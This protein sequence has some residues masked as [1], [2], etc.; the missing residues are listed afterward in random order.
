MQKQ[1]GKIFS[2]IHRAK[3]LMPFNMIFIF[4]I[5]FCNVVNQFLYLT[6]LIL[7]YLYFFFFF[8]AFFSFWRM[9]INYFFDS[10]SSIKMITEFDRISLFH[11]RANHFAGRMTFFSFYLLA[12]ALLIDIMNFIKFKK[13]LSAKILFFS[14]RISSLKDLW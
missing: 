9:K 14:Y 1:R 2:W 6:M 4:F 8:F 5:F 11:L 12:K 7:Y 3:C 13:K 10:C